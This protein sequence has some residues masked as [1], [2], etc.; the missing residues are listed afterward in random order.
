MKDSAEK[1]ALGQ[2]DPKSINVKAIKG[3]GLIEGKSGN[4]YKV[5]P[6]FRNNDPYSLYGKTSDPNIKDYWAWLKPPYD[7]ITSKDSVQPFRMK[8]FIEEYNTGKN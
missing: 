5:V 3:Y 2:I 8:Q 1:V 6:V 7:E 4:K